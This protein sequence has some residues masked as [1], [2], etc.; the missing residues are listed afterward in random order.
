M[1]L[2]FALTRSLTPHPQLRLLL[3][4]TVLS[5]IVEEIEFRGFGVLQLKNRTGW[6]FWIVVWPSAPRLWLCPRG[7]GRH[8]I[9]KCGIIFPYNSRGR[10]VRV[11]GSKM[12]E[13]MG[14][15][16][17]SYMHELV[18]AFVFCRKDCDWRLVSIHAPEH[19]DFTGDPYDP[20]LQASNNAGCDIAFVTPF[21]NWRNIAI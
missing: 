20:S 1:L 15:N 17:P 14:A 4:L 5:P 12:A 18:V 6:P 19:H 10:D 13:P 21:H 8:L 11:V 9:G 2:G 7:A 3:F 16:R